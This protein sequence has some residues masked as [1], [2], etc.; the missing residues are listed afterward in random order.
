M[1]A[2]SR[3][4]FIYIAM[5]ALI[6]QGI[7]SLSI[8]GIFTSVMSSAPPIVMFQ[9]GA[10]VAMVYALS[11]GVAIVNF[12]MAYLAY[13]GRGWGR[14]AIVGL[15][16][17]TLGTSIMNIINYGAFA[18]LSPLAGTLIGLAIAMTVMSVIILYAMFRKDVRDHFSK[19]RTA[20]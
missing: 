12:G 1:S 5:V 7:I 9:L 15:T 13:W 11:I 3:P 19:P 10:L 2:V 6:V 8:L 4:F 20:V 18:G 17:L 16:L 14:W